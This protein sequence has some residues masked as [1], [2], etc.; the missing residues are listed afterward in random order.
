M[1][2]ERL[3]FDYFKKPLDLL[4]RRWTNVLE[5]LRTYFFQSEWYEV[6]DFVE[7]VANNYKRYNFRDAFIKS[8][9]AVLEK[10]VSVYRFI[11]GLILRITEQEQLEEI[12]LALAKARGPVQM[13]LRRALEFLSNRDEP[14]YR[15][16]IKE[17]ISAVEGG[18][19]GK[20]CG[21]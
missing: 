10:K 19:C 8:C 12:E 7:F 16:S 15:N 3:W 20:D 4:D 18:A 1:L 2:C 21:R 13:H 14:D 5:Q 9:N 11:D 17:S 6:Y